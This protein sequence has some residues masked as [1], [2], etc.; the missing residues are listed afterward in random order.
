ML[1]RRDSNTNS[2]ANYC[3]DAPTHH[4]CAFSRGLR[5][6]RNSCA[7][8]PKCMSLS[9]H[10]TKKQKS[11]KLL[12]P[13]HQQVS[14]CGRL[15]TNDFGTSHALCSSCRACSSLSHLPRQARFLAE[16]WR[17]HFVVTRSWLLDADN[18]RRGA[19]YR[20][21]A[22]S[23]ETALQDQT[24]GFQLLRALSLCACCASRIVE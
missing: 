7:S 19:M 20:L 3:H 23:F 24:P 8:K 9:R 11:A 14:L 4:T 13:Q 2:K 12:V 6:C 10:Q 17:W 16:L 18:R 1:R 21:C 15:N 5:M 22:T